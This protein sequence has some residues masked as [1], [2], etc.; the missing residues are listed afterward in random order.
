MNTTKLL[1][2]GLVLLMSQ[3]CTRQSQLTEEENEEGIVI[4]SKQFELN[5]M[6][7][8]E[9]SKVDF[10]SVVSC[11]A[12]VVALPN[13]MVSVTVPVSGVVKSIKVQS[14]NPVHKGQVLF[15]IGGNEILDLQREFVQTS[16]TYDRLKGEYE[17]INHLF[18][19]SVV[20]EKE[21]QL[22]KSEY[23]LARSSYEVLKMKISV[24]G[25]NPEDISSG[26]LSAT[27]PVRA[28]ISGIPGQ[29]R[30]SSG[31]F[32]DSNSTLL[33]VIDPYRLQLQ[34]SIFESDAAT[35]RKGQP[36]RIR[37]SKGQLPVTAVISSIGKVLTEPARVVECYAQLPASESQQLILNQLLVCDV[38]VSTF[39]V[40]ALPTAAF[41]KSESTNYVLRLKDK[42][43]EKYE[44]EKLEVKTGRQQNG[45]TELKEE[46]KE[47]QYATDG[48]YNLVL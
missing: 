12:K 43:A 40:Q 24:A 5:A 8:G 20:P 29:L 22:V 6:Q 2:L 18:K 28:P 23:L 38:I 15:E 1:I 21:Y 35:I 32:V 16:A 36:V 30:I 34:L 17:R 47:G 33:E 4:T 26:N 44:F 42:T 14:G 9:P 48:V 39:T 41:L 19:N 31:S 11:N 37:T 3:S 7:L 45:M 27:Y 13:G 10:D 46:I 25:L